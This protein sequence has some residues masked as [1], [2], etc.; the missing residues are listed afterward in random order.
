MIG[1]VTEDVVDLSSPGDNITITDSVAS[2]QSEV[3]FLTEAG[4]NIIILL[5]HSSYE[6][7]KMIA[8]NTTGVDVIVGGH[9]T[10]FLSIISVRA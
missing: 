4:V 5:S 9:Y 3:D 2:V 1:V 10:V 8:A 6:T 7:D